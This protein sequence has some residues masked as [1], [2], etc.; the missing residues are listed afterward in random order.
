M[1]MLSWSP[2]PPHNSIASLGNLINFL[3]EDD[4]RPAKEQIDDR[5][6]AGGGWKSIEGFTIDKSGALHYPG[7]PV[8]YPIC[9][10][11][12]RFEVILTYEADVVA[13]FRPDGSLDV[14]RID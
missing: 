10:A 2:M 12:L 6:K 9:C 5:Y 8:M 4:P 3:S 11:T 14:A 13:I 1:Q 7:D